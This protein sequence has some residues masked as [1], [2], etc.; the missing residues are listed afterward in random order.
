VKNFKPHLQ[1]R[2]LVALSGSQQNSQQ[3]ALSFLSC[4][5]AFVWEYKYEAK[6]LQ[7]IVIQI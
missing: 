3:G 5:K 6:D 7:T 2:I 4:E 1:S